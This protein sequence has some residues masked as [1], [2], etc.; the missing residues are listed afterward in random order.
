MDFKRETYCNQVA[1]FIRKRIR[2]GEF[3]PGDAVKEAMLAER[4]GISRA[5]IR[6]ALQVLVQEGLITSEPQKGKR[7]RK[8]TA[9]EIL[10]S[11]LV[12][13]ILEGAGVAE[14]LKFWTDE[15]M[16]QLSAILYSMQNISDNAKGLDAL[17]EL[18]DA[19]HATLLM[20][21]DNCRLVEIARLSCVTIS[22]FLCYQH[23]LTLYSPHDFFE[24]HSIISDAVHSR[25]AV[26]VERLLRE[27]YHEIG[28]RM[29]ERGG[30]R[31][32]L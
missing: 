22:K 8:V 1:D 19:F 2:D 12:G 27:H 29:S 18:D 5:P 21:C 31:P 20:R 26:L 6:E 30:Y 13:G 11:Y 25:D 32:C 24:R 7:V 9:K 3:L 10:D 23:W 17:M 15:D 16:V 14:S 28:L 4:L